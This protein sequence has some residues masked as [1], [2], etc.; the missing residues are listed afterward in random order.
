[1]NKKIILTFMGII[2]VAGII[3][4]VYCCLSQEKFD[5]CDL[6][7]NGKVD[8][9]EKQRCEQQPTGKDRITII[10]PEKGMYIGQTEVFD[11]SGRV[12]LTPL[13]FKETDTLEKAIGKKAA[14]KM[15]IPGENF[16]TSIS[17]I[18][19]MMDPGEGR[20]DFHVARAN[21]LWADGYIFLVGAYET[22]VGGEF[23]VVERLLRGEFDDEMHKLA[24]KFKEFG[25]PMFFHTTR[26]PNGAG[27]E[28]LGGF[29]IEGNK[30]TEWAAERFEAGDRAAA[31]EMFTPP[32][33]PEGAPNL[34]DGLGDPTFCDGYERLVAAQRYY[35][36]FFV[37]REGIN[38]LTFETMGWWVTD[39]RSV[40]PFYDECHN[41]SK[42]MEKLDGY[43]DWV[44]INW[45]LIANT[46]GGESENQPTR[47]YL[48]RLDN[49]MK[50]IRKVAPGKPVMISEIGFGDDND[51][52]KVKDGLN[53]LISYPEIS[54]FIMWFDSMMMEETPSGDLVEMDLLMQIEP[55]TKEGE[56]F[57]D[58]VEQN[59]DYFHSCVR[60]S[61]GS[62]VANC[63]Q[64]A[65]N[66]N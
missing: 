12:S 41:Y 3:A 32:S 22:S 30:S 53:A 37:R 33:P 26:E 47:V 55:G 7:K 57:R 66:R 17:P 48:D 43:Y 56:A 44:S 19:G 25:K 27:G 61:D 35:Y 28:Y 58:F 23:R 1:M 60:F 21:K 42:F 62:M 45:Y 14:L 5:Q 64:E 52:M 49:F 16:E 51:S 50:V 34:Y 54:A 46:P 10:P 11:P 9:V 65:G 24:V 20:L 8:A 2:L 38:F 40:E 18:V 6:N 59:P 31:F 13:F 29:G 39:Q 36:D 4:G 63:D 15:V